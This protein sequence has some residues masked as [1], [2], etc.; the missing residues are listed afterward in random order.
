MAEEENISRSPVGRSPGEPGSS[1]HLQI[2]APARRGRIRQFPVSSIQA[3][4]LPYR[5]LLLDLRSP[6]LSPRTLSRRRS[7][8]DASRVLS[9]HV[10]LADSNPGPNLPP[11][12]P[13]AA[14]QA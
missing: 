14:I 2:S 4:H 7:R 13:V 1:L 6:Q 3:H 11:V 12:Q 5:R 9:L 10:V 8:S